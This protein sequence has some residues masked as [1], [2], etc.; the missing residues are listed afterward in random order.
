MEQYKKIP[1]GQAK[2]L[3]GQRFGSLIPLYRTEN[4]KTLTMW[5]CQCDCGNIKPLAVQHF[6]KHKDPSCGCLNRKKASERMTA[7]NKQNKTIQIGQKYGKL[8]VLEYAGLRKQK[9]RDKNE[10]WYL[11]KCDCGKEK[12]I[13]GSDMVTGAVISCGCISSA[14]EARIKE[15]LDTNNIS[16]KTEYIF[17]DLKNPNTGYHLRFDFAIFENNQ[18]KYL[19]EFDG[20][21]HFTGPESTW[22]H[23][24]SLEDIQFRDNLKNDYCKK[25]NIILK[26][27]P[28]T[29]LSHLS[30]QE[31]I[32]EQYNI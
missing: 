11:C 12:E 20:R 25:N 3:T 6:T 16:Y 8:T 4:K 28:Y 17:S 32:G 18:L 30:Y 9:S 26:R 5:V 1:I 31:I 21:Q 29:S 7:Y 15:I 27:I 13:R 2:D 22:T 24:Y 10:S 23:S 14:G 19:I